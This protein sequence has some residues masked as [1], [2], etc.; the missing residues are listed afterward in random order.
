MTSPSAV[1]AKPFDV[2]LVGE[3]NLDLILYGLPEEMPVERE[4]LG[5]DFD[6]NSRGSSSI[7]AHNLQI[8]GMRVGFVSEVGEDTF[9]GIALDYL[10]WAGV[11]LTRVHLKKGRRRAL[12]SYCRMAG[13]VT[14]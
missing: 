5:T 6:V 8:L 3:T 7:L 13:A 2:V 14:S 1:T 12:P 10:G 4:T 9:G 11:D